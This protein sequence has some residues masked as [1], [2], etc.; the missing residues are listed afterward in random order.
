M[1]IGIDGYNLAMP[2]GTGVATYGFALT[3]TLNAMGHDV[4]GVFGLPVGSRPE[5]REILFFDRLQR[6][7][8]KITKKRRAI[9]DALNSIRPIGGIALREVPMTALVEKD[10]F[11]SRLP[12][13]DRVFSGTNL[14]EAAHAYF[15]YSGQFV[16][17]RLKNPP[18]IMHWTYPVPVRMAGTHNIYTLH[19]MVPLRL[20]YTTLDVKQNYYKLVEKCV[21]DA[22]HICTVSEASRQ[23]ILSRFAISE[24]RLTNT[25][26]ASPVPPGTHESDAVADAQMIEGIFGLRRHGYFLYF[27]AIEPKKNI[28]RL[29][30]SYLTTQTETPLV[31]VGGR[32]WDSEQ[33]LKLLGSAE[34]GANVYGR[35][36]SQRIIRL[37][38]L[39]RALLMRLIRGAKAVTFPSLY[40]GFGLPVHEAMLMGTPVL[41]SATSSIPE[42]AGDAAILVNPY[43][44]DAIAAGLLR[45]DGDDAL[46]ADLSRRGV[47]Q[48]RQFSEERY[49]TRLSAM[50]AAILANPYRR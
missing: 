50:Y 12:K 18:K 5:L 33:E 40:E 8:Q 38:Y 45:L 10:A 48:A 3:Q 26:Q 17:V 4:D 28:G 13:F 36:L 23:D 27:G 49:R 25:F 37:D 20:P 43:D 32:S 30:E 24:H 11:A 14:F 34:A 7:A 19:D 15:A 2:N 44:N 22:D 16:T 21:R 31:I 9:N 42:V 1:R 41:S 6:S 29:I 39:P 35:T 46:R 47:V